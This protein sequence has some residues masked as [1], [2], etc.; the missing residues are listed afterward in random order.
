ME[1]VGAMSTA[2]EPPAPDQPAH[3]RAPVWPVTAAVVVLGLM[4][5]AWDAWAAIWTTAPLFGE[6]S[7][8]ADR[9]EAGMVLLTGTVPVLVWSAWAILRGSRLGLAL[10]LAPTALLGWMGVNELGNAGDPSA[11]DHARPVR[12]FDA[13]DELTRGNWAVAALG[14]LA[15]VVTAVMRHRG[16]QRNGRHRDG[17]RAGGTDEG[18]TDNI[19]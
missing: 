18:A 6:I 8:R 3:R 12:W 1:R 16:A 13:T 7:T 15:L 10:L 11:P 2:A 5:L 19:G 4:L 17:I 9:I 14:V